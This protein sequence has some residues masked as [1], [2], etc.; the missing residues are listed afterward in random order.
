LPSLITFNTK[1][2]QAVDR[3]QLPALHLN[4]SDIINPKACLPGLLI[5]IFSCDLLTGC[6]KGIFWNTGWSRAGSRR[7]S[8][9]HPNQKPTSHLLERCVATGRMRM[10]LRRDGYCVLDPRLF[11]SDAGHLQ[12]PIVHRNTAQFPTNGFIHHQTSLYIS[13]DC[14]DYHLRYQIFFLGILQATSQTL[15]GAK[16][17]LELR[18][19]NDGD[20]LGLFRNGSFYY[21]SLL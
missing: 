10:S 3:R 1:V 14:L 18:N 13:D 15:G 20:G 12:R 19:S 21:L 9:C 8:N 7:W 2:R 6:R 16:D 5:H 11:V 17:F 4:G